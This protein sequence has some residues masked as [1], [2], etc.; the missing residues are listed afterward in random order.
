M[1]V[2]PSCVPKKLQVSAFLCD[3]FIS[4]WQLKEEDEHKDTVTT[5]GSWPYWPLQFSLKLHNFRSPIFGSNF[6]K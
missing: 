3:Q 4:S 5:V 1:P 2:A 6:L